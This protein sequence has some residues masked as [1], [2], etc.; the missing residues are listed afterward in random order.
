[1]ALDTFKANTQEMVKSIKE[2]DSLLA[3]LNAKLAKK[4][5]EGHKKEEPS[6]SSVGLGD[7]L[8]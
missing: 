6:G 4:E 3:S 1:M 7:Q 8:V 5:G 2:N